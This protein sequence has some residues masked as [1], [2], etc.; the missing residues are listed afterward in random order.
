[1]QFGYVENCVLMLH[2]FWKT[3]LGL[4]SCDIELVIGPNIYIEVKNKTKQNKKITE[5]V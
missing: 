3:Q 1:M 5:K 2:F 4:N